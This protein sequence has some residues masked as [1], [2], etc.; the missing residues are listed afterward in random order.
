MAFFMTAF[1]R[2]P[3]TENRSTSEWHYQA[4]IDING[5]KRGCG[6]KNGSSTLNQPEVSTSLC[7]CLYKWGQHVF[8]MTQLCGQ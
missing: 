2:M 3:E 5:E 7:S 4:D 8:L 6:D 1:D